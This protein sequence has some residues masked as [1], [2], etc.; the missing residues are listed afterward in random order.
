MVRALRRIGGATPL[1]GEFAAHTH[2][3]EIKALV[4]RAGFAEWP[5]ICSRIP[6]ESAILARVGGSV[7]A[8]GRSASD[9][10]GAIV[11]GVLTGVRKPGGMDGEGGEQQDAQEYMWKSSHGLGPVV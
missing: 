1:T 4:A 10:T 9:K 5:G 7:A 3:G 2:L 11:T 8:V 6:P